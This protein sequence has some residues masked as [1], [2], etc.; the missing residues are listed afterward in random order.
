VRFRSITAASVGTRQGRLRLVLEPDAFA[1]STGGKSRLMGSA[2]RAG[3]RGAFLTAAILLALTAPA[4]GQA[5]DDR[6]LLAGRPV[7]F[8]AEAFRP[9]LATDGVLGHEGD[10]ANASLSTM[11]GSG[12]VL[13]WDLKSPLAV[14]ALLVQAS[15]ESHLL[16]ELSDDGVGFRRLWQSGGGAAVGLRSRMASGLDG[17]GR[18][19]RLR[20]LPGQGPVAIAEV[21][22]FCRKPPTLDVEIRSAVVAPAAVDMVKWQAWRK[23][24]LGL[25]AIVALGLSWPA[26]RRSWRGLASVCGA[27]A[28][29]LAM[30]FTFGVPGVL[31]FGAVGLA[32]G[33]LAWRQVRKSVLSPATLA[34]ALALIPL[35][36]AGPLAYTN[37][38]R[39]GGYRSVH[40][41]DA[42]HYF[43]GAKYAPELG[44]TRLYACLAVAA[45]EENRWP[46]A[47]PQIVRDLRS[48]DLAS[49]QTAMVEGKDCAARFGATR[50]ADFRRDVVF[51][52]SQLHPAAWA[53]LLVDHGYNA[54]PGWTFILRTLLLG[55][56]PAS[57][58][59]LAVLSHLDDVGFGLLVAVLVWGFGLRAGTLAVLII[60]MGFPWIILWTGGGLGRSLWL[61]F[62]LSGLAAHQR[63]FHRAAGTLL[64]TSAGLQIFPALFLS[65]ALLA[66]VVDYRNGRVPDRP[67]RRFLLA[68]AIAFFGLALLSL[69]VAGPSLWL[70]FVS[71][72]LKHMASTSTN[73]IG[74]GQVVAVLHWPSLLAWLGALGM[75]VLWLRVGLRQRSD[76]RRTTLAVCLPLFVF[77][78]SS[79]YLAVLAG[80]APRLISPV[81]VVL[82][83]LILVLIPQ[84]MTYLTADV[85][86][87]A[88]Y[89]AVSVL[90]L[91][92]AVGLL[93]GESRAGSDAEPAEM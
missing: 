76:R 34:V 19:L 55:S 54:T 45:Q 92:G 68:S 90:F 28:G 12:A 82:S 46:S 11:L 66:Q 81:R 7:H 87:P 73:R 52:Q 93:L 85:P 80:V 89:A 36:L 41:H 65:G 13:M 75:L 15:A 23:I 63:G 4:R 38:G 27:L 32:A 61:L 67:R 16:V 6:N 50:W 22:A 83:L 88:Y 43:L 78:L 70:D 59:W 9:E 47:P 24:V 49:L 91:V 25:L 69:L 64:G 14:G 58:P 29:G 74:L 17:H 42:A 51:F 39:W 60:G 30:H 5:C 40:Y 37:F 35:L 71:N 84:A 53:S 21:Q 77:N 56:R 8:W 31:A 10:P 62:G 33:A 26:C 3:G 44:Y 48:N 72:G 1:H 20:P 2:L 18:Y 86:G 79:Y 57:T